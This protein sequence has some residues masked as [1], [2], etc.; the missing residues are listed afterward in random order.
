MSF[1]FIYGQDEYLTEQ[2]ARQLWKELSMELD[3][4]F[5]IEIIDGRC[6]KVDEA[7]DMANRLR[8]AVQTIGLFGGGRAVWVKGLNLLSDT[9]TGRAEAT[10]NILEE[11]KPIFEN[12]KPEEVKILISATPVDKRLTFFKWFSTHGESQEIASLVGLKP[13][14]LEA[15]FE[16]MAAKMGLEFE[17]EAGALF[18][19]KVGTSARGL[20]SELEKLSTY[21]DASKEKDIDKGKGKG[22]N[23]K[24]TLEQV[25]EVT[26]TLAEGEFFEPVEAFYSRKTPW[27]LQSLK[28]YFTLRKDNDPRPL[29]V[30]LWNRNRLLMMIRAAEAEG[31]ARMGSRGLSF[32]P[33]AEKMKEEMGAEKSPFNLF[34]QHPF[35]LGKLAQEAQRFTLQE[36]QTIQKDLMDTFEKMHGH[37]EATVFEAFFVKNL[38]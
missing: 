32:T 31:Y 11:L 3:P 8:G 12:A 33:K 7:E 30:T 17:G 15:E 5:G 19:K 34:A 23:K 38:K 28:D 14:E 36:L 18:L 27:A 35:Y 26:S 2:A 9:V 4:E 16:K 29:I 10:Q 20:E 24:V 22:K 6:G 25:I 21:L 1:H 13:E 37:D